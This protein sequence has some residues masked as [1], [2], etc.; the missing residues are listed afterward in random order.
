MLPGF[1]WVR[2][3]QISGFVGFATPHPPQQKGS[4]P[5]RAADGGSL[6]VQHEEKVCEFRGVREKLGYVLRRR[7]WYRR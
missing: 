1:R 5:L 6:A 4:G 2:T 3:G 7:I